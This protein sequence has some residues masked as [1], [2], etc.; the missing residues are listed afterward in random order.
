MS[1]DVDTVE[2]E[3]Y[4]Y[5]VNSGLLHLLELLIR[6]C[7]SHHREGYSEKGRFSGGLSETTATRARLQDC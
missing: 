6:H 2:P 5:L 4:P 3:R 1:F 7:L